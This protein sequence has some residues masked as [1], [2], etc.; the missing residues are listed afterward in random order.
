[1]TR[2]SVL[3]ISAITCSTILSATYF[4]LGLIGLFVFGSRIRSGFDDTYSTEVAIESV[5]PTL[6]DHLL[7]ERDLRV[8]LER[9][10]REA[11]LNGLDL[12]DP[13]LAQFGIVTVEDFICCLRLH[14]PEIFAECRRLDEFIADAISRHNGEFFGA[15]RVSVRHIIRHHIPFVIYPLEWSSDPD[16]WV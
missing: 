7:T 6:P 8:Q 12:S 10:L 11:D 5:A 1:M 13:F 15:M 9:K 16:N 3:E 2:P 14:I 4:T